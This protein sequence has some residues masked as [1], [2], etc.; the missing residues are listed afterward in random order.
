MSRI[1]FRTLPPTEQSSSSAP[2]RSCLFG[3]TWCCDVSSV[4]RKIA[5]YIGND[6]R[7]H[8][9]WKSDLP[10]LI[11]VCRGTL[12]AWQHFGTRSTRAVGVGCHADTGGCG[13]SVARRTIVA[14]VIDT[15]KVAV[16]ASVAPSVGYL[17]VRA[18][19]RVRIQCV[20]ALNSGDDGW[21]YGTVDGDTPRKTTH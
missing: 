8:I 13:G 17:S 12:Q 21:L 20:G 18:G 9:G 15:T 6:R 19:D 4:S 1:C 14:S 2:L 16:R 3:Q 7:Q 5:G 11:V 10:S